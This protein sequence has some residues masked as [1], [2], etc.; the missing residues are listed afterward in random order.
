MSGRPSDTLYETDLAEKK[1]TTHL[2]QQ[3]VQKYTKNRTESSI[4]EEIRET[5]TPEH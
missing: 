1:L 4:N 2:L 5:V 3:Q